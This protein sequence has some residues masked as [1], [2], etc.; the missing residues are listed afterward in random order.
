MQDEELR[1]QFSEWARPLR[2][3]VPPAVS[4]IRKRAHRRTAR[5]A[6]ACVTAV[7]VVAASAILATH[8]IGAASSGQVTSAVPPRLLRNPVERSIRPASHR[9]LL[10]GRPHRHRRQRPLYGRP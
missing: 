4:V 9:R 6:A 7:A 10:V 5:V 3:A 1:E 8:D 2:A